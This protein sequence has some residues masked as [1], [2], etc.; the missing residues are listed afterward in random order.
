MIIRALALYPGVRWGGKFF[1]FNVSSLFRRTLIS[2]VLWFQ[3]NLSREP[4]IGAEN[5][6]NHL[7]GQD[8]LQQWPGMCFLLDNYWVA[9][10]WNGF[11]GRDYPF[12]RTHFKPSLSSKCDTQSMEDCAKKTG[13]VTTM[14]VLTVM[15][16]CL[17]IGVHN[18]TYHLTLYRRCGPTYKEFFFKFRLQ[19]HP[20]NDTI[21]L[22]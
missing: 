7:S 19:E 11:L 8:N 10:A 22:S 16:A 6:E 15:L 13:W 20:C 3:I 21:I 1:P 14:M 17:S 12:P 18:R 2:I 4:L 5:S 9:A